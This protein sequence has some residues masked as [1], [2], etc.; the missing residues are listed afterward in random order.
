MRNGRRLEIGGGCLDM[1]I[2]AYGGLVCELRGRAPVGS[3]TLG[4]MT[5]SP[6][7]PPCVSMSK[8]INRPLLPFI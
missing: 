8:L 7:R 5:S 1:Y 6:I 4:M 2:A 3:V